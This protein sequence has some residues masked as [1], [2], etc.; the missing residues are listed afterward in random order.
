MPWQVK[1]RRPRKDEVVYER[2]VGIEL[3]RLPVRKSE[4]GLIR[5]ETSDGLVSE[6]LQP[7]DQAALFWQ[8]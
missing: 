1:I 8:P 4:G 6:R 3:D 2:V 7:Q 5:L